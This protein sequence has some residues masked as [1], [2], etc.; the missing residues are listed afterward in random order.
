MKRRKLVEWDEANMRKAA[1]REE[2][3][4]LKEQ[5]ASERALQQA[6][7]AA[8]QE[9]AA[10]KKAEKVA[11]AAAARAAEKADRLDLRHRQSQNRNSQVAKTAEGCEGELDVGHASPST[12]SMGGFSFAL[13]N[14]SFQPYPQV[15]TASMP[16]PLQQP[17]F[18]TPFYYQHPCR[19]TCPNPSITF[20]NFTF[21]CDLHYPQCNSFQV[22]K[23]LRT[24]RNIPTRGPHRI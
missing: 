17:Q 3:A 18:Q 14:S 16:T 13:P 7:K 24:R 9:R 5:R 19:Q 1:N 6:H 22:F 2:A 8:E 21:L 4:R 10:R 11:S 20:H 12:P 15:P 23:S